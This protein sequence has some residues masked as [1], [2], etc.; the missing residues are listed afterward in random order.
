MGNRKQHYGPVS[1]YDPVA[2]VFEL[3]LWSDSKNEKS[4][5]GGLTSKDE[6]VQNF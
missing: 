3:A 6:I 4:H 1:R 5:S 2:S